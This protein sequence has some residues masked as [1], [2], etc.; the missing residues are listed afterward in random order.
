MSYRQ[1]DHPWMQQWKHRLSLLLALITP[2]LPQVL[3][4]KQLLLGSILFLFGTGALISIMISVYISDGDIRTFDAIYAIS[5]PNL[6]NIYPLHISP[7]IASSDNLIPIYPE[8]EPLYDQ[9]FFWELL[10]TCI[11]LSVFCAII[12]FWDQW[13]SGN[14]VA[15]SKIAE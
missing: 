3:G 14:K 15:D 2:G 8:G 1:K 7:S 5:A 4:R 13:K 10:Y 11:T 6:S 9:S 12:S